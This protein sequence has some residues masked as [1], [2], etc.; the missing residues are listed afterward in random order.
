MVLKRRCDLPAMDQQVLHPRS[1]SAEVLHPLGV[2]NRA[3]PSSSSPG[4]TG[5][6]PRHQ[7]LGSLY[8]RRAAIRPRHDREGHRRKGRQRDRLLRRRHA[9]GGGTGADGAG[10]RRPHQVGHLLHHAGRLHHAGDLK[11]FVD[12]EQVAAVEKSMSEKGYLDGTKMATA[13][14]MLRSGDLIGPMSSTN[15]MRGKD[16]LPFDLL[17]WNADSTA[18][19]RPTTLFIA[20]L[21]SREQPFARHDGTGGPHGLSRR[22]QP[23]RSTTSPPRKITS[24]RRSPFSS[25]RNIS[26]A[27]STTS[28]PGRAI[29]QAW[30]IRRHPRS[31]STG[32][33]G[34]RRAT[35]ASGLPRPPNIQDPGGRTARLDRDQ[36]QH[37]RAGSQTRQAYE[38]LGGCSRYL[39]EGACVTD[40]NVW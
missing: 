24:R 5:R 10:R 20:Q 28:W 15:Y 19:A 18:W 32:P 1:Q 23:F 31:I 33:E 37:P 38:N 7:E 6:A 13:F 2:L 22:H 11:V 8:T 3:T 4:S 39:C 9:A 27:R 17:Y 35:S 30:S 12:E 14:N 16:P 25:A 26:A 36:G 40:C 21:L 34:R 29:S